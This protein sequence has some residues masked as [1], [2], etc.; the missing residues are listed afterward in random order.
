MN[1]TWTLLA[2]LLAVCLLGGTVHAE[3][4]DG[5]A[6]T[7]SFEDTDVRTA[8]LTIAKRAQANVILHPGVDGHG[9]APARRAQR[10]E[11]GDGVVVF[12]GDLSDQ[13]PPHGGAFFFGEGPV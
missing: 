3:E 12:H 2:G 4:D 10:G 9:R 11:S 6:V 13:G 1:R 8:I 7:L 5:P